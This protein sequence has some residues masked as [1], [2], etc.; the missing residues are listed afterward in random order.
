MIVV[1]FLTSSATYADLIFLNGGAKGNS[2]ASNGVDFDVNNDGIDELVISPSGKVGL[3]VASPS[4]NLHVAGNMRLSGS[5]NG[6]EN[7]GLIGW[8]SFDDGTG[9]DH[10]GFGHTGTLTNGPVLAEGKFGYGL[11]FDGTNDYID[12]ADAD[13][14]SFGD[15]S[16][17]SPFSMS[18][19]FYAHLTSGRLLAKA[20]GVTVGE[21]YL[22]AS[23]SKLYFRLVDESATA[24]LGLLQSGT[25]SQNTWNHVI[26]TYNGD[27]T[28]SGMSLYING[29]LNSASNS[30]TGTYV[31]MENSGIPLQ[32]GKRDTY[33]NGV[34]D[35]ARLYDRALSLTEASEL[36]RSQASY[37]TQGGAI[38]GNTI[39]AGNLSVATMSLPSTTVPSSPVTGDL[40]ST[41]T[42]LLFRNSNGV[43]VSAIDTTDAVWGLS[44]SNLTYTGG[45]L[46]IGS[47]SGAEVTV[48]NQTSTDNI[49]DLYDNTTLALTIQDGGYLG[50]GTSSPSYK[51]DVVGTVG[52]SSDLTISSTLTLGGNIIPSSNNIVNAGS[53]SKSWRKIYSRC[54]V[55]LSD[56]RMKKDIRNLDSA[57]DLIKQ[58]EPMDYRWINNPEQQEIGL[59]AQDLLKVLPEAVVLPE[60]EGSI[61]GVQYQA[62]IPVMIKAEQEQVEV[63]KQR[64]R[65]FRATLKAL[66]SSG[67]DL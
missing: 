57:L 40:Y 65:D 37:F 46:G 55:I 21:Y 52:V 29:V 9:T 44:S 53:L 26:A 51:L 19:W 33:F 28:N 42:N 6:G 60:Q 35:D 49:L 24:Y 15:G 7:Q 54:F 45:G 17:D 11:D 67:G 32:I 39:F 41:G 2:N 14:L 50:V 66:Q 3:G 22:I 10:S 13:D 34:L 47:V 61:M 36:Y 48:D 12:I 27:G 8:W 58:I 43:W 64:S 4:A 62:L 31:A 5:I 63:I 23:G 59:I 20:T 18:I 16:S 25:F 56:R 38:T 30:N 1:I